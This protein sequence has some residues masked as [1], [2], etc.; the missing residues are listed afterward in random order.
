MNVTLVAIGTS[1]KEGHYAIRFYYQM[2][3]GGRCLEMPTWEIPARSYE[4]MQSTVAAF[5]ER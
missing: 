2:A 3:E 1:L 5:N 4:H